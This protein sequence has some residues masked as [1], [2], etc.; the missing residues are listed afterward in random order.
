MGY[1][2][3]I[4]LLLPFYQNKTLYL[5]AKLLFPALTMFFSSVI[6]YQRSGLTTA[7]F[8]RLDFKC[9]FKCWGIVCAGRWR[10]HIGR[11][12]ATRNIIACSFVPTTLALSPKP[13]YL[14]I[15]DGDFGDRDQSAPP[16]PF[17][18]TRKF[19]KIPCPQVCCTWTNVAHIV[20]H[21]ELQW[22]RLIMNC[23]FI[24][25]YFAKCRIHKRGAAGV[26]WAHG[27]SPP[28][29]NSE[30]QLDEQRSS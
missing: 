2:S 1:P 3:W 18:K 9:F 5:Q 10:W 11:L 26:I 7:A 24:F 4:L 13:S 16:P 27:I 15:S 17:A 22:N 12:F 19:K 14:L 6:H 21:N 20:I 23:S 25:F 30:W 8:Q 29:P 28:V